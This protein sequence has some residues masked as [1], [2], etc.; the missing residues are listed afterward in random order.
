MLYR[1]APLSAREKAHMKRSKG[2][3]APW[4]VNQAPLPV[5][6][7]RDYLA[8]VKS[9]YVPTVRGR[10]G[11][12]LSNANRLKVQAKAVQRANFFAELGVHI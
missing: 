5:K 7:V 12:K 8:P 11:C 2:I 10:S 1:N 9:S 6:K 4:S 3:K